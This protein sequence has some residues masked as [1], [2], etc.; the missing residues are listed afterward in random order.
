MGVAVVS[1]LLM[2]MPRLECSGVSGENRSVKTVSWKK[3][4]KIFV[5]YVIFGL[6]G[7]MLAGYIFQIRVGI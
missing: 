2:P 5:L 3:S 7:S 6:F 1:R 4:E